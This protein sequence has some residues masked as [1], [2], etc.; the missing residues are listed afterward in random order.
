VGLILIFE[1]D[2]YHKFLLMKSVPC[3]PCSYRMQRRLFDFQ[4]NVARFQEKKLM[5]PGIVFAA[6]GAIRFCR[7]L[8]ALAVRMA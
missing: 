1:S 4:G 6:L 5:A 2:H 3:A 7:R 8:V